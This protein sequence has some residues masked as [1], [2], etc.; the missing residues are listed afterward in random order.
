ML[1]DALNSC[2]ADIT[3]QQRS[4]LAYVCSP[5]RTP[6]SFWR[7]ASMCSQNTPSARFCPARSVGPDAPEDRDVLYFL[8]QSLRAQ[9]YKELPAQKG[10]LSP[11]AQQLS[12][13]AKQLLT[14][15][16]SI[17]LEIAQ[18]VV[19]GEGGKPLPDWFLVEL[20]R[21]LPALVKRRNG[22]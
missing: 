4:V 20:V 18:M 10:Q 14:E 12:Y 11:E 7:I 21:E 22:A 19:S 13:R 1:S 3:E 6:R 9:L 16:S 2:G 5:T 8:A 17:S 15:L